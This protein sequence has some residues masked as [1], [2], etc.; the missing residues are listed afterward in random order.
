MTGRAVPLVLLLLVPVALGAQQ[1][2]TAIVPQDITVGDVFHI[3]LQVVPAPE[4][5]VAFPDSIVLPPD[6]EPAGRRELRQDTIT[7]GVRLSAVYPVTGWRPGTHELSPVRLRLGAGASERVATA[8]LPAVLIRSVLPADTAGVQ[9][10]PARDVLGANRLWWPWLLLVMTAL[11]VLA[12][13]IWHRQ[14]R[15]ALFPPVA[16][17]GRSAREEALLALE[18][19][20]A[21]GALEAGDHKR[22][23]SEVSAALRWYL[24]A[25]DPGLGTDLTTSELASALRRQ[26]QEGATAVLQRVLRASDLVKFARRIPEVNDALHEWQQARDWVCSYEPARAPARAA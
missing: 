16:V 23:Y 13:I 2:R 9:P 11:L 24:A 10:K 21:S 1:V 12:A 7:Q 6:L 17:P 14:R 20:R 5:G 25:L 3:V 18:R 4:G 19:A 8:A 26:G 22:F 15:A